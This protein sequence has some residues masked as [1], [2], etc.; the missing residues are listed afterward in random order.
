ME[1]RFLPEG[2]LISRDENKYYLSCFAALQKAYEGG[3]ILEAVPNRCNSEMCLEFDINGIKGIMPKSE[4]AYIHNN[5]EIRDIAVITRVGKPVCF[6]IKEINYE[7][8]GVVLL[9]SRRMAQKVCMEN[10]VLDLIPGDIILS[11]VTHLEHFGAFVDIGNGIVSL[12]PIDYISVSRISHPSDR[13]FAGQYIY[14]VIK[15]I[16]YETDRIYVSH[17]ELLGSWEENAACFTPGQTV[18]GVIRSIENYGTFVELAPNLAGLAE[19]KDGVNVGD[20]VSVYIKSIIPDKMKI[21]LVII[22]SFELCDNLSKFE[23]FTDVD[24]EKHID[25]FRYSPSKCSKV[26]ESVF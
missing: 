8:E 9:L 1:S 17:K 21:K 23:Y 16:D 13:L 5:E 4:A 6:I 11:R 2:M 14:T 25:I 26:I 22:E 18:S 20:G 10:Y 7:R 3:V 19:N 24:N 12:L 15:N